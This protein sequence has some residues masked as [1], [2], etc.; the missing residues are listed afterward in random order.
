MYTAVGQLAVH[1]QAV[2]RQ[3]DTP[4]V[5]VIVLPE[6]PIQRLY[7]ILT[8]KLKIRVLTFTRSAGG[9]VTID[10]LKQLR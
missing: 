10:G 6:H 1:A 3:F 4:L 9:H 8:R 5:K 7:D 2:A